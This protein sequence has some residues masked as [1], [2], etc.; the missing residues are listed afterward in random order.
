[1]GVGVRGRVQG[2]AERRR[3]NTQ[4]E[5]G[6]SWLSKTTKPSNTLFPCII[7]GGA[8]AG[9]WVRWLVKPMAP[10]VGGGRTVGAAA[11]S[12][13]LHAARLLNSRSAAAAT[14][15][16]Q[17]AEFRAFPLQRF[18]LSQLPPHPRHAAFQPLTGGHVCIRHGCLCRTYRYLPV[19]N[20]VPQRSSN[21]KLSIALSYYLLHQPPD[22]DTMLQ[23]STASVI[24]R[25][26]IPDMFHS[27]RR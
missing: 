13:C 12:V 15:L 24:A 16:T 7:H 1:M 5:P 4:V 18:R 25:Q 21:G 22:L 27:W 26:Y 9:G 11:Q 20:C 19:P 6:V 3:A 14:T 17:A 10:C 8:E 23:V 2:R